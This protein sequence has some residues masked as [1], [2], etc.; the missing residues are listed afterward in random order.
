MK[1]ITTLFFL[2]ICL[3][4][5]YSQQF[6]YL[7][8]NW[9]DPALT[10]RWTQS[11]IK[12]DPQ[13]QF[14]YGGQY[15]FG[16]NPFSPEIPKQGIYNA[17]L[18]RQ[19]TTRDSIMIISPKLE[20]AAA[21]KP[22]LRFFHCQYE[23]AFGQDFLK[24]FFRRN[25]ASPWTLIKTYTGNIDNW[26]EDIIDIKTISPN[27]FTDDFQF[28]FQG[29]VGN[30]YG[31]Y[32]DSV[33]VR[34]DTVVNKYVKRTTYNS[35]EYEVIP[36]GAT[37]VPLEEIVI[38]IL[39]NEG[40]AI[41]DSLTLVPTGPGVNQLEPNSFKLHFTSGSS[42]APFMADTSTLIATASLV[43]GKVVFA[44]MN[45][46][47]DIGDNH[48]WFTASFKNTVQGQTTVRFQVPANGINVND[49]LF[50]S[51][52]KV[53]SETHLIKESV[54]YDNFE[55]GGT[56]WTLQ[57]NFEVG[58]PDGNFIG[59]YSNPES[60]FNGT[61]ILATDLNGSYTLGINSTTA[62]YAYS[63]VLNLK[64]Y[65]RPSIYLHSYTNINGVDQG[66]MDISVDN[67]ATWHNVWQSSFSEN[68]SFW[69][70][71]YDQSIDS[72]ANRQETF[73]FRVGIAESIGFDPYPGFGIDN[74]AIIAEKLYTDVGV[75]RIITPYNDCLNCGNDT[76][77]A[78]F[79]N[80]A[81]GPSPA[82]IPVY[83]ALWGPD[84]IRVYDTIVNSIA[85]DDSVEFVFTRLANFPR[86]DFYTHFTVGVALTGDQDPVNDT[87]R[88]SLVIQNNYEPAHLEKFEYKGGI[89]LEKE[90]STWKAQQMLGTITTDPASPTMWV[91]SP[92]GNYANN[93]T[94]WVSSGC[95]DLSNITRNILQL[96]VW[97]DSE[98]ERD[99]GRIE[100]STN[101]GLSWKVLTDP[102]YGNGWGWMPDT[103][104]ALQSRGW[105]GT[106]DWRT[107]K[108]LLPLDIDTIEK[109]RFRVFYRSDA[110]NTNPQG[111][112]FDDLSIFPAP[113][114]IGVT[115][116]LS[117]YDACQGANATTVTVRVQNFGYNALH[118]NDTIVV[119]VD[120]ESETPFIESLILNADLLPGDSVDLVVNTNIDIA[121]AGTYNLSA[122]TL[123]E[124]NPFYYLGNNDTAWHSF[125][126]WPNPVTELADTL[127]SRQPDTLVVRPYA[128]TPPGYTF[129]WY[130]ATTADTHK[131]DQSDVYYSLRVTEPVHSCYSY[132]SVY[133]QLL[134]NDI[135]VD[136]IL[137]P[138]NS[139][140]LSDTVHVKVRIRNF[141]TDSLYVGDL[142][143]VYFNLDGGTLMQDT[144]VLTQ[145]L[146]K[147]SSINHTFTSHPI[148]LTA[149]R[150]YSI[151]SGAYFGGDTVRVNDT[152][153]ESITVFGYTPINIGNDTTIKALNYTL[154]AGPAF[155]SYLWNTGETTQTKFIDASVGNRSGQYYVDATD[156]NG[157]ASSDS[158]TLF[159][160]IRDVRADRLIS[161][162]TSCNDGRT[163]PV[164][165][166]LVNVGTDTIQPG[167]NI[168][169][170]YRIG[171]GAT[172]S[173]T[174][175]PTAQIRPGQQYTHRFSNSENFGAI[176]SY[177][178]FLT[179]SAVG[180]LRPANDTLTS[181]L[182]TFAN[183]V[184]DLGDY[185]DAILSLS[186]ELNAGTGPYE[187]LWQDN[188]TRSQTYTAMA[189]GEYSVMVT[190]TNTGCSGSDTTYLVF[191]IV[192]YSVLNVNGLLARV[193][194]GEEINLSV[195]V[196]NLGNQPR[197]NT[198][199]RVG[200]LIPG[201]TPV[202]EDVTVSG[203]WLPGAS[204][205]RLINLSNPAEFNTTGTKA[206]KVY[207]THSGDM[208]RSND[209]ITRSTTVDP[210][211]L[212]DFGGDTIQ[213]SLPYLLD[214]GPHATYQWQ[215]NYDG[216][217]YNVLPTNYLYTVTVTD[218]GNSCITTKSVF[219]EPSA[220]V[221]P[222]ISEKL[223]MK[224]YP[225]PAN[226][227]FTIEAEVLNGLP[228][229]IEFYSI[230]NQL[231]WRDQH[232]GLGQYS[233]TVDIGELSRGIYL[234]RFSNKEFSYVQ[235]VIVN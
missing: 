32:V 21:R 133:V 100:Y 49:T 43:N 37:D 84:T 108:A 168:N 208:V 202:N 18:F 139:C 132:D 184:V 140:E 143:E 87:L 131:V 130:D 89:W 35:V 4:S 172:V 229:A 57:G 188:V 219:V 58:W 203:T 176:Q 53:L 159:F 160:K 189:T 39:G 128:I 28:A 3:G 34:E 155:T 86:G 6:F 44:N 13:W 61:N 199:I 218:A 98:N 30:G 82:N 36:S 72:I 180:D 91:L 2:L 20:L 231:I 210:S 5:A 11:P 154:N 156:P 60:P 116:I 134:F 179:T 233:R 141:G 41:L 102:V 211:P 142:I 182:A 52:V 195:Q 78:W 152:I 1:R 200:Y 97:T 178:L 12:I 135:G 104:W 23:S 48:L 73:Q 59:S 67:G 56:D 110:A 46:Y 114:D 45:R 15:E 157:C 90:G 212:V 50:P 228:V 124:N 75:T 153:R 51:S 7:I 201:E 223:E 217:F 216:R 8:E 22:T 112:A 151:Y 187:Y 165:V 88:K 197:N 183:P 96:K 119:G 14:T 106:H 125:E 123:I 93:D 149:E 71:I 103:V 16:G 177:T 92:T 174:A 207:V 80:Y 227:Y 9:E 29:I 64:Y 55:S 169:Y 191:D 68:S 167:E 42:Y 192:D 166:R 105:T 101:D 74:F 226:S 209:T 107:A 164:E 193:C 83:F 138:A 33:S 99:G 170:S 47:L 206:I 79:R 62:Y 150:D 144:I 109:A 147:N 38:R 63:K 65:V 24:L 27:Y 214:A 171:S 118:A 54:F 221:G 137:W 136:N 77:R 81:D 232:D 175:S 95:Y 129:L 122:Y 113:H 224:I 194:Q 204:N 190:D 40:N 76:I 234:L 17:G 69:R 185:P 148:D 145:S 205:A 198:V 181:N 19:N 126:V 94:S 25:E 26:D 117:P 225:N 111:F 146:Y 220:S 120:F 213:V 173:E 70:E 85:K 215:D 10:S 115:S 222:D 196:A 66:K 158:I 31:V 161:P 230:T 121:A 235:R 162:T 127:F 163:L 186:Y